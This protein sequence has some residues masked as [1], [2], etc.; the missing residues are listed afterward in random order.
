MTTADWINAGIFL[1]TAF[2]GVTALIVFWLTKSEEKERRLQDRAHELEKK[3][4]DD[5]KKRV[6]SLFAGAAQ[7]MKQLQDRL[8]ESERDVQ[9]LS[10]TIQAYRAEAKADRELAKVEFD[11][12]KVSLGECR[13]EVKGMVKYLGEG[14]FRV[15]GKKF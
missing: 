3:L 15:S 6:D 8:R 4:I 11:H 13:E 5:E 2:A 7:I 14:K 12:L 1:A 10:T 9:G